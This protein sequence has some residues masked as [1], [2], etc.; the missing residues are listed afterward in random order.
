MPALGVKWNVDDDL[1]ASLLPAHS[2]GLLPALYLWRRLAVEGLGHAGEVAYYG[3]APLRG[4]DGLVDVLV[5]SRKGTCRFYFDPAEGNLLAIEWFP[6]DQSDP[7]EIHFSDYP[8]SGG[9][10]L[11]GADGSP[12]RRRAVCRSEDQGGGD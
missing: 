7:C 6:D 10:R 1:T 11:A 8:R 4:H 2:G 5:D 9:A 12:L 3:T